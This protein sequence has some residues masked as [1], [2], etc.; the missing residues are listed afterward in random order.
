MNNKFLGSFLIFS[1]LVI[2]FNTTADCSIEKRPIQELLYEEKKDLISSY[3]QNHATY[4]N[5][6][7]YAM[8]LLRL[9]VMNS[10]YYAAER[11]FKQCSAASGGENNLIAK[12]LKKDHGHEINLEED[13]TNYLDIYKQA[14]ETWDI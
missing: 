4:L 5:Q 8:G 7:G 12:V 10:D 14:A 2:S 1:F 11:K 13:C 9:G 6:Y 3:C